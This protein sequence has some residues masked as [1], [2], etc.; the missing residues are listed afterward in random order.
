[1]LYTKTTTHLLNCLNML[2]M[3]IPWYTE[4][5]KFYKYLDMLAT[6]DNTFHKC[7][8]IT[9]LLCLTNTLSIQNNTF[10]ERLDMLSGRK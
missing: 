9:H 10:Y 4:Y 6:E 8:E 3:R 1:M 7:P 5:S 2:K